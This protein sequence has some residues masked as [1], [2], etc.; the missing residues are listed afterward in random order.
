MLEMKNIISTKMKSKKN[1]NKLIGTEEN[2]LFCI[3]G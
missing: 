3:T 2:R 1:E